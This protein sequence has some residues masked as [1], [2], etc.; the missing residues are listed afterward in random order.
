[1]REAT[2]LAILVIAGLAYG[3]NDTWKTKPYQQWDQN[4]IKQ[5]LTDSPWVKHTTVTATWKKES[6]NP[7]DTS[8]PNQPSQAN[9]P[10]TP[11]PMGG[12]AGGGG[13]AAQPNNT[14]QQSSPEA[15]EAVFYV[16]W[17]SSKTIREAVA[18]DDV[19]LG[20]A[21]QAQAE[22]YI[23]QQPTSYQ[24]LVYGADLTPFVGETNDT[25]KT[26]A[27][28]EVKPS[29]EKVSPASVTITKDTDG[30]SVQS[31]LFSF[32]KQTS[33][34]QPLLGANDK[35]VQFDCKLKDMHLTTGFDLR[36][37]V[38]KDGPDF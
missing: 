18:R 11:R 28:L 6:L 5:I 22:Q 36:K 12:G 26:K 8:Q 2:I 27:Y 10:S 23:D 13:S 20:R 1:M 14:E 15:A 32:S 16:R 34:G 25:L 38:A 4:D 29:K 30:K 37:M 35:Q 21:S 17:S 9:P 24:I 7:P 19:L 3:S 33:S 31:V